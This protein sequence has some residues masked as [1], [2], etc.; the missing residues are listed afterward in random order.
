LRVVNLVG[1]VIPNDW[2]DRAKI[3]TQKLLDMDRKDGQY[4]KQRKKFF[5][6]QPIWSE[7][8][9]LMATQSND[10][11]WYCEAA[12]DRDFGAVDHFRPKGAVTGDKAHLGYWWLAYE[13]N[14]YRFSCTTCNS[15]KDKQGKGNWFPL[16]GNSTRVRE[17]DDTNHEYPVLLDPLLSEDAA[18]VSFDANGRPQPAFQERSD[19]VGFKR[20]LESIRIYH[21]DK[22]KSCER[23]QEYMLDVDSTVNIINRIRQRL[24]EMA[25]TERTE[26]EGAITDLESKIVKRIENK[27]E[28]SMAS[29]WALFDRR[30]D[31]P[32]V[33]GVL[34]RGGI[35]V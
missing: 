25:H 5:E 8:K 12:I 2:Q 17:P 9:P 31:S 14:N 24:P 32:W 11:C 20:V 35:A 28:Y 23:R 29:V 34:R 19:S 4:K 27:A 15:P 7:I 30:G 3:L 6:D 10:K 13:P 16:L 18:M 21:W 26:F 33:D 1:L 22:E